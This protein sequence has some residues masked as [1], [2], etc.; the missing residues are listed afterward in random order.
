MENTDKKNWNSG[1]RLPLDV[2]DSLK[3]MAAETNRSVNSMIIECIVYYFKN[4]YKK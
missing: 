3:E 4:V 2:A 1:I